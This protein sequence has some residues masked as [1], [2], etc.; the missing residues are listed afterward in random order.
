MELIDDPL[1]TMSPVAAVCYAVVRGLT[2]GLST[3]VRYPCVFVTTAPSWKGF[4]QLQRQAF[5]AL[6]A[7]DLELERMFHV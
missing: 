4:V 2:Y 5:A 3:N 6:V 1:A 7:N